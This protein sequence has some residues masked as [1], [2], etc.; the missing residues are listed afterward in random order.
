MHHAE[1]ARQQNSAPTLLRSSGDLGWSAIVAELSSV[2]AREAPGFF[3]PHAKI[4][5]VVRGADEGVLSCNVNGSRWSA[6]PATGSIWLRPSRGKYNEIRIT[7]S[8]IQVLD[9]YI[10]SV[11]F[12][13]LS[14][15]YKLPPSADRSIRY[16]SGV[17]DE[18]I[19]QVG[20]SV[21]S[22]MMCPTAA[23]RM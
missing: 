4:S 5:I 22:E 8:E 20:L 1:H 21:L 15:H 11:V 3:T 12:A 13:N 6:R 16:D 17:R 2:K 19:Y 23:G 18:V 10:P 7:S 9:L 14:D